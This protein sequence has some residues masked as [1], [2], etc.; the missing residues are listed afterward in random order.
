MAT[1]GKPLT[2]E[3][4][5]AGSPLPFQLVGCPEFKQAWFVSNVIENQ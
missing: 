4:G 1:T 5:D 2:T 3:G